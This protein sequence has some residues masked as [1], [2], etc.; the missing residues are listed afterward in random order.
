MCLLK[1]GIFTDM[2]VISLQL[3]FIRL[4]RMQWRMPEA[5]IPIAFVFVNVTYHL[6]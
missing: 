5:D 4:I 3:C 1:I 2:Y 6:T